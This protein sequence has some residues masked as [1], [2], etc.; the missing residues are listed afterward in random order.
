MKNHFIIAYPGNKRNEVEKIYSNLQLDNITTI[1]E[2]FCGTSAISYYLS[3]KH[4]K[5]FK[6]IINTM[7]D[8]KKLL[9]F[10]N[11]INK[12]CFDEDNNFINKDEYTKIMKEDTFNSWFIAHK[13]YAIRSGLYPARDHNNM[14]NIEKIEQLPIVHFLKNENVTI[15]QMEALDLIN[16]CKNKNDHLIFMDPPYIKNSYD[17]YSDM[18]SCNIYEYLYNNQIINFNCYCVLVLEDFWIIRLLF[19][20]LEDKTIRYNKTYQMSKKKT[21]HLMIK[22]R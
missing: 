14:L 9:I 12:M 2:P 16:E 19:K 11:K 1:I 3:V 17:F 18:A 10:I 4:P 7:K 13:F 20:S 21:T 15:K 22:N 8:E 5:K 6:Y